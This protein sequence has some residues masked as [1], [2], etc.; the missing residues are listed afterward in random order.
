M[1]INRIKTATHTRSYNSANKEDFTELY[2]KLFHSVYYFTRR[3]I[4]KDEAEDITADVFYNV[5]RAAKTFANISVAKSYLQVAARNSCLNY[6]RERK[7]KEKKEAEII[8]LTA[9]IEIAPVHELSMEDA[10]I[11]AILKEVNQLPTQCRKVFMLHFIQGKS[12]GQVASQ[13]KISRNTVKNHR[14]K[15]KSILKNR[16]KHIFLAVIPSLIMIFPM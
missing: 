4:P 15:A 6:L 7:S 10:F 16:L 12:V 5:F 13:L 2:D 3:F 8:Y 14:A 9:K 1:G 11:T